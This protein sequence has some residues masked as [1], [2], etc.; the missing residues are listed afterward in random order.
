MRHV[1]ERELLAGEKRGAHERERGIFRARDADLAG[2][3]HPPWM[4]SLSIRRFFGVSV[5]IDSA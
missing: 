1:G 5:R 4:T 2:E 3:R